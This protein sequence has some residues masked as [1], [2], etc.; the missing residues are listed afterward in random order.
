MEA[1]RHHYSQYPDL[2]ILD[3]IFITTYTNFLTQIISWVDYTHYFQVAQGNTYSE[4]WV[5]ITQVIRDF[6]E[7]LIYFF[8]STPTGANF[9]Y[10]REKTSVNFRRVFRTHIPTAKISEGQLKDDTI[11]NVYYS[12]WLVN[13]SGRKDALHAQVAVEKL[14]KEV[15]TLKWYM[16]S[17]N[18]LWSVIYLS[19]DAKRVADKALATKNLL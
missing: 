11:V 7:E 12:K 15:K 2:S 8:R 17:Q 9:R 19:D 3:T 5:L 10:W 14:V 18:D 13:H 16:I 1:I 4:A 6:F